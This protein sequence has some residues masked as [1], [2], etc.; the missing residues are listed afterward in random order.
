MTEKRIV[1]TTWNEKN[2]QNIR[3]VK[4]S[5]DASL[6]DCYTQKTALQ[7]SAEPITE[8]SSSNCEDLEPAQQKSTNYVTEAFIS[9]CDAQEPLKKSTESGKN[10]K[11]LTVSQKK[12]A[13]LRQQ[14]GVKTTCSDD[15]LVKKYIP[16]SCDVCIFFCE[17]FALLRNHFRLSHPNIKP[18]VCCCN[19]KWSHWMEIVH[20]AYK[21]EDPKFLKY[22][23]FYYNIS[24]L[25]KT[26]I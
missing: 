21:H 14:R 26:F 25:L 17:D 20:H 15:E 2:L 7:E 22:I 12:L 10:R 18:Y 6:S 11:E 8:A 9:D 3:S 16:M 1:R 4:I 13:E 19:R 5:K 23:S 24:L